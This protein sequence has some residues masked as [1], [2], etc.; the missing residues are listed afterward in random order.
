MRPASGKADPYS[1]PGRGRLK[2]G[3]PRSPT[4]DIASKA[5]LYPQR[6]DT[7]RLTLA[8]IGAAVCAT[9][10]RGRSLSERGHSHEPVLPD[11]ILNY[12]DPRPGEVIVDGTVGLGGH[13]SL[14]I[15]RIQ[16]GGRYIGL[17]LDAAMLEMARQRL[18]AIGTSGL[19]LVTANYADF[20]QVLGRYGLERVDHVL[21]DLGINS[22]QL[23][24]PVRGFSFD[25][26]GPLDMRFNREQKEQALDLVNRLPESEL[27]DLFYQFGQEG[28]SRKIAKRICQ[29]RHERR[30]TTTKV[31]AAAVE[32]VFHSGRV[33]TVG[34][35]HPATRVF[36]A[37]RVAVNRELDNLSRFLAGVTEGVRVGGKLAV[38]S[39]HSLE[40]GAVKRFFRERKGT[41]EWKELTKEPVI[42]DEAE[43][44]RNPRSRSAKLR[45]GLRTDPTAGA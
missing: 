10:G 21:L 13:A 27:A 15:P 29:V 18:A 42:A 1:P 33:K 19:E 5:V 7:S 30:I 16:P 43:R 9:P 38:I 26:D 40:D 36:Q 44:R 25:A 6:A 34:K 8:K 24:D 39:F 20:R 11:A 12:L 28:A 22:A 17:D 14:L 41:G 32:S 2:D 35:I 31:L 23:D 3:P 45:V 4:F 37:L